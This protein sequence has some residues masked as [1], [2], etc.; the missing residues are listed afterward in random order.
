MGDVIPFRPKRRA[1][2]QGDDMS[3]PTI[4]VPRSPQWLAWLD[5]YRQTGNPQRAEFMQWYDDNY[6]FGWTEE[7]EWP[8]RSQS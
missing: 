6:G 2:D 1:T 3:R 8:L 4:I 7:T 5:H